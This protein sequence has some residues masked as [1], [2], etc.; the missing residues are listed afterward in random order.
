MAF[1]PRLISQGSALPTIT[2]SW[3]DQRPIDRGIPNHHI[4][5][6]RAIPQ[7]TGTRPDKHLRGCLPRALPSEIGMA[8]RQFVDIGR[9]SNEQ[10]IK[11]RCTTGIFCKANIRRGASERIIIVKEL[12]IR[13]PYRI[14]YLGKPSRVVCAWLFRVALRYCGRF[15]VAVPPRH[16]RN[17][18]GGASR[19]AVW[20]QGRVYARWRRLQRSVVLR[21]RRQG[22]HPDER[23]ARAPF[24]HGSGRGG[25]Y[26]SSR[27]RPLGPLRVCA[28]PW[29]KVPKP[30]NQCTLV[31]EPGGRRLQKTT[32][33]SR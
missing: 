27:G 21:R 14:G 30:H 8:A 2:I 31:Q 23:A 10:R 20:R 11:R 22:L 25:R 4:E 18:S 28:T 15:R 24:T 33:N 29:P 1:S 16:L 19:P 5:D 9:F 26:Q 32:G 7:Q 6:C 17:E 12:A 13:D 3:N